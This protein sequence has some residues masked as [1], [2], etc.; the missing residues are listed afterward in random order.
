MRKFWI[1]VVKLCGWKFD[2]PNKDERPEIRHCVVAVAPHTAVA[3]FFVGAAVLFAAGVKPRIFIKKEFFNFITN[4]F[5]KGL[6]A[7]SVDRGN[8]HNNLVQRA[9][10]VLRESDDECVVITPEGTRK[11]VKRFKRGFYEIAMRAGVPI[12]LGFMDF[13]TKRAGYGPTIIPS[14]DFEADVAKMLE[15]FAP[16]H[17][18]NPKGWHWQIDN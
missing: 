17:A 9:T 3:D 10:E 13:K 7:V 1:W 6:G 11:A 8:R 18:K 12:V 14:G 15:F 16:I 2:I 5:L 4:P